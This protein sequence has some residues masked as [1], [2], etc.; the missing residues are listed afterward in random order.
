LLFGHSG[1]DIFT[2]RAERIVTGLAAQAAIAMDNANLFQQLEEALRARDEFLSIAAHEL[3]TPVAGVKGF[4]QLILRALDRG[5]IEPDRLRKS[6]L[7]IERS[8]TRLAAL[9]ND[10]LDVSRIRLGQLPL[11]MQTIDLTTFAGELVSRFQQQLDERHTLV[12]VPNPLL[13]PV[14]VDSDRLEQVVVNLLENAAK[15]SPNGGEI[16]LD[17]ASDVDGVRLSVH[18]HGIG[19]PA[20]E[21]ETIFDPFGRAAN[22]AATDLPGLG[23][24]LYISRNIIERHGGRI[25]AESPGEGLGST[26]SLWLPV[27]GVD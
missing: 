22:A 1:Q 11:R 26:F 13:A 2:E 14:A 9:T 6:V 20:E 25:W 7:S 23:L 19:L 3:R 15:Y 27:A 12:L 18:D 17:F 8:S 24:G 10:L 16:R 21:L 5:Q 4:S